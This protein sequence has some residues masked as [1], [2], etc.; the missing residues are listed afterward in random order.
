MSKLYSTGI[1]TLGLLVG[2][3]YDFA[4]WESSKEILV[5]FNDYK[6]ISDVN[7]TF[8][9]LTAY[10]VYYLSSYCPNMDTLLLVTGNSCQ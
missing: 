6:E 2:T 7:F 10:N 1:E 8:E 5:K 9:N 3:I 4:N